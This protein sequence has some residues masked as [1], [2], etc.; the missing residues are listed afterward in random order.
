MNRLPV[1][2]RQPR[3]RENSHARQGRARGN[4]VCRPIDSGTGAPAFKQARPQ[5]LIGANR[6]RP[7]RA[8]R[9]EPAPADSP[10]GQIARGA[11]PVTALLDDEANLLPLDQGPEPGALDGRDMDEYVLRAIIRLNEAETL[12]RIEPFNSARRHTYSP[13]CYADQTNGGVKFQ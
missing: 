6:I 8:G 4:A 7:D 13:E 3:S 1:V 12:S 9:H 10:N 5:N 11:L 2:V